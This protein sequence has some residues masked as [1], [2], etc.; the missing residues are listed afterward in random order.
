MFSRPNAD[1]YFISIDLSSANF[2]SLR[3]VNANMVLNCKSY[4]QLLEKV[5]VKE[6]ALDSEANKRLLAYITASKH[7]RQ[8]KQ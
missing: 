2:H 1:Q 3:Y 5:F 6:R 4:G 8:G 7:V